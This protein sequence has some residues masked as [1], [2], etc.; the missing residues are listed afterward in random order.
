MARIQHYDYETV[1]AVCDHCGKLCIFNRVSDIGDPGRYSGRYV[2][3]LEC[4]ESFWIY[5]DII[6][7]PFELLMFA[8]DELYAEKRYMWC[9]AHLG[10]AWEIFLRTFVYSNY[11]FRP[12]YTNGHH[13]IL[14]LERFNLLSSQLD[15]ALEKHTFFPLRNV[16]IN[17]VVNEVHPQTLGESERAIPRINGEGFGNDPK[18]EAIC[19]FPDDRVRD[20][21]LRLQQLHVG[22]LRNKVVHQKAYRPL[23]E[24]AD[25]CREEM[26]LMYEVKQA[27]DVG[28]L[29]L[30][31][32][33]YSEF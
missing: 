13:P 9:V 11:L 33:R 26:G 29:D 18:P 8:A 32:A 17:T 30:W 12:F 23:R 2:E 3:C 7:P 4:G 16:L 22:R 15:K 21:L 14:E 25:R 28:T 10:Q 27:L 19:A 5:G 1:S 24:E 31:Q 20:L 6:N